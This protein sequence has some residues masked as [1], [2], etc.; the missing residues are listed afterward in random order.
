MLGVLLR[1]LAS[2]ETELLRE[3]GLRHGLRTGNPQAVGKVL[4]LVKDVPRFGKEGGVTISCVLLFIDNE[5]DLRRDFGGSGG[6]G[7]GRSGQ[8]GGRGGMEQ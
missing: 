6:A 8:S 7:R 5:E 3:S 4:L 1:L 2:L